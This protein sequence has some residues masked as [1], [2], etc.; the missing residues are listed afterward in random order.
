[1]RNPDAPVNMVGR[2]L[3]FWFPFSLFCKLQ[4]SERGCHDTEPLYHDAKACRDV[5]GHHETVI[6]YHDC[7]SERGTRRPKRVKHDARTLKNSPCNKIAAATLDQVHNY[8]SNMTPRCNSG[9]PTRRYTPHCPHVPMTLPPLLKYGFSATP[10][11]SMDSSCGVVHIKSAS[12]ES[13]CLVAPWQS[14]K[15][16]CTPWF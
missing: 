9:M 1:M 15:R 6:M 10:A 11:A 3:H 2:F 4:K 5:P 8:C 12:R 13:F 14:C 16:S 7:H